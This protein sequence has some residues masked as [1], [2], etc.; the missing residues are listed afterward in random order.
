MLMGGKTVQASLKAT[1]VEEDDGEK[2]ILGVSI[3]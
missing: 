1:L 3:I 2:I